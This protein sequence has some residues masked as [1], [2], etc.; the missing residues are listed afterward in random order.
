MN[1]TY[2]LL[3]SCALLFLSI[4]CAQAQKDTANTKKDT[5]DVDPP[6]KSHFKIGFDFLSNNVFLGRTDSVATPTL[7]PKLT[8]TFKSGFYLSGTMDIITNRPKNKLDGGSFELGYDYTKG[9]NLEWGASFTK[10][11]FNST[12]TQVSSSI[13]SELDAY[14]DYD[15]A[16]IITPSLSLGYEIAKAGSSGDILLTPSISHDFLI[17]SVFGDDDELLISPQFGLNA[18]S[19]NFYSAYLERK[20]KVNR[21][22]VNAAFTAY[23]NALGSFTLLDYELSV[24]FVYEAGHFSVNFTPTMAFAQD[25]LPNSTAAEKL[26]TASIEK[27]QPIKSNVFYLSVGVAYKF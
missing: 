2:K 11:F 25:Q 8:Y 13:S 17:E 22:G 12:S 24:P 27:S 19:Q 15:I 16:D 3:V 10:L 9:E 21:K 26:I 18:G 14:V 7:S 23:D 5:S 6:A 4:T 20:G 1:T